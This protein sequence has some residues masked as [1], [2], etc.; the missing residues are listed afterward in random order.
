LNESFGR[1][2]VAT[3]NIMAKQFDL[4]DD[5]KRLVE[6]RESGDRRQEEGK[7]PSGGPERRRGARRADDSE[8]DKKPKGKAD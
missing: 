3:S 1:R 6:K 8:Q 5:L 7:P 2:R 4:P